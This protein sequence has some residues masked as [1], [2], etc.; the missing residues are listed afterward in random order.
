MIAAI[1]RAQL[2]TMRMGASRGAIFSL[3]TGVIWYGIAVAVYYAAAVSE[4]QV[5]VPALPVAF[6]AICAYWQ[7]VPVISASMGAGLDMRKLMVYAVPHGTLFVVELLL[8]LI[9]GAE[10]IIVL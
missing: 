9:T 6:L 5:L 1:L 2:L 7:I 3:I 8:R 10:M 4:P